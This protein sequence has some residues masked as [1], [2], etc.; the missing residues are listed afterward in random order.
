MEMLCFL[1]KDKNY[2]NAKVD[3]NLNK[4]YEQKF[5]NKYNC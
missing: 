5:S 3:L 2:L 1:G 4:E